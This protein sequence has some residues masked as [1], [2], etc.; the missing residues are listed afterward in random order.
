MV[1]WLQG[2]PAL[3]RSQ[4]PLFGSLLFSLAIQPLLAELSSRGRDGA[5]G[6]PLDLCL[7]YLDDGVFCGSIEA[8]SQSLT[9]LQSRCASL[10]L[11]LNLDK[12]ELVALSDVAAP[13]LSR[14]FPDTLLLD[15]A[16]GRSRVLTNGNFEILG[17]AIGS[18]AFCSAHTHARVGQNSALLDALSEFHD[19]QI[20]LRLLRHCAG[21]CKLV[22]SCRTMPPSSHGIQLASYD[23]A[24]RS[25]FASLTGLALTDAQWAQASRSTSL[26]GLGLR[27]T[28]RHAPAAYVASRTQ[29][30]DACQ[31]IDS[32]FLWEAN[33][34]DSPLSAALSFLS[35]EL[36]GFDYPDVD[37][38]VKLGQQNLS[39]SLDRA[40]HDLWF[41]S[42]CMDDQAEVQSELLP[43]A[44]SFLEATPTKN[45]VLAWTP[46]EFV[47]E[48]RQRLLLDVF[49]EDSWCPLCDAVLDRKARHCAAFSCGGDRVC[50]HNAARNLVGRFASAA[51]LHPELEKAGLLQHSPDQ[52]SANLRR[53]AD[54]FMPSGSNGS[55]VALD[56]AI[57]TPHRI[58]IS[59]LAAQRSGAA[60]EEYEQH[61]RRYLDTA[62]D[63][64]SQG[65][66][67]VPMVGEPTGGWG[68][69]AICMLKSLARAISSR[70]G[71][72][73]GKIHAEH[74][75]LLCSSIRRSRAR[76]V[77]RRDHG[78]A[79]AG[80][81]SVLGAA[82]ILASDGPD[83]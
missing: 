2:S 40:A 83:S 19:P 24:V 23:S 33:A 80:E 43:G 42:L 48:L 30:F 6:Q 4:A 37:R 44:S 41:S 77:F 65:I 64:E 39:K 72:E 27:S 22:F 60:A 52:P 17:A 55:P 74:L 20:G 67:F 14:F 69:S 56:L 75:Q 21:F 68:S 79:S 26:A 47:S 81:S 29:T 13:S 10:G 71:V 57:T 50:R 51:G 9:L 45:T 62:A 8:V 58:G 12:C 63:C 70:T 38:P 49:A 18:D 1:L 59:S 15:F 28:A 46:E 32:G 82:S 7:S 35:Q 54:V 16:T 34:S 53:P 25:T 76:A 73:S 3:R 61:K 78:L 5:D 36:Q 31:E 66:A 11:S